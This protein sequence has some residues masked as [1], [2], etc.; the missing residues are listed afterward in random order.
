MTDV[1]QIV[2]PQV[3]P[4]MIE[5]SKILG[6]EIS[7]I[8][9]VNEELLGSANDDKAG[10]LSMLRQGS[11][12][13]TLQILFDNLDMSQKLLGKI[14]IDLVQANFTPGKIKKI[15]HGEEPTAQFYNKAFGKYD[16]VVEEG[17]NTSTQKQ[18]QFAQL[19]NLREVG[20]PIPDDLLLES[21]TLQNKKQLV[22][23]VTKNQRQQMQ[24]AQQQMQ[25]GME[26][27]KSQVELN[28]ARAASDQGLGLERIS[29]VEEN[30]AL[31]VER[32][33]QAVRD[34]DAGLLYKVKALKELEEL[35]LA[36][37]E[38]LI[39]MAQMLKTQDTQSITEKNNEAV[40]GAEGVIA[41]Q[42]AQQPALQQP[43]QT[44]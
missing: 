30:E 18:M 41:A 14:M 2:A 16:A 31:A 33:A 8:S 34:E 38:R 13:T 5:L 28:Q 25:M 1:Q 3:P 37:L 19:I 39:A 15:L 24:I 26:L 17:L 10:I 35:D 32:K 27:Q 42:M 11:G 12:L 40:K 4:S 36:H 21:A 29:R 9:G 43:P 23:A 7:Q 6:E 44:Q 20:V 22:D